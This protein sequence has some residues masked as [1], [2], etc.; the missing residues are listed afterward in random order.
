MK[1][2]KERNQISPVS[3]NCKCEKCKDT[4]W[5]QGENGNIRCECYEMDLATR[6]WENFGI[7]PKDIKLLRDY[8]PWNEITKKAREIAVEYITRFEEIKSD[9]E[10]GFCLMGQPGAGKT[11]IV[12][13]IGKAL[14]DKNIPVVY[15]PYLEVMREL[16]ACSMD[17]EYYNKKIERYRRAKVLIIDDLF[18]DKV[19]K[20]KLVGELREADI[21][22]IYPILNY[23]Y[24]NYLPTLISTEC[25]P[26]IL[27]N[28][29]EALAGRILECCGKRFGIVFK[30][31]CNYRLKKFME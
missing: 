10:N 6:L 12:T 20:G 9:R 21:K 13:A 14:L 2:A 29:D 25:T 1:K 23:R 26:E 30:S 8:K 5:I 24:L 15:M 17:E 18:K 22:H 11:H 16:K 19:R 3:N 31:E 28:L 4:T 27:L 7:S